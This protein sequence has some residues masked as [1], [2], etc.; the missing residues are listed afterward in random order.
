MTQTVRYVRRGSRLAGADRQDHRSWRSLIHKVFHQDQ[1]PSAIKRR[2]FKPFGVVDFIRV[3]LKEPWVELIWVGDTCI[4]DQKQGIL[5]QEL[6]W[7]TL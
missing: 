2:R 6:D 4:Y 7:W 1:A 5:V 3:R